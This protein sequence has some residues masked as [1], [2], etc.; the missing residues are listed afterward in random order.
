M[1]TRRWLL[2]VLTFALLVAPLGAQGELPALALL[3]ER[4]VALS[5]VDERDPAIATSAAGVT[6]VAWREQRGEF[7][8]VTYSLYDLEGRLISG[9][10]V[11]ASTAS[12]PR[13]IAAAAAADGSFMLA[14]ESE[15]VQLAGFTAAG[16][17]RPEFRLSTAGAAPAI[18][19]T[20]DGVLMLAYTD[21]V[22]PTYELRLRQIGLGAAEQWIRLVERS[23]RP[24]VPSVA[25][26]ANGNAAVVYSY[27]A[28]G[29]SYVHR[30]RR[31]SAA[32]ELNWGDDNVDR[33]T[34][35]REE[36]PPRVASDERGRLMVVW[37]Q[38]ATS[39]SSPLVARIGVPR[40]RRYGPDGSSP[41]RD[42]PPLVAPE[43]TNFPFSSA[44]HVVAVEDNLFAV[45]WLDINGLAFKRIRFADGA[46]DTA[47]MATSRASA[48]SVGGAD[49]AVAL[50]WDDEPSG[51]EVISLPGAAPAQA[52]PRGVTARL[53]AA[54]NSYGLTTSTAGTHEG[55]GEPIVFTVTRERTGGL[56]SV[57]YSLIGTAELGRDYLLANPPPGVVTAT[58][59]LRFPAGQREQRIELTIID[60]AIGEPG[61]T[62]GLSLRSFSGSDELGF[63]VALVTLGDNDL[64]EVRIAQTGA[65]TVVRRGA[66]DRLAVAL[67]TVP[68]AR[69]TL[70]LTPTDRRLNLG[71]GYGTPLR[72]SFAPD[73]SAKTQQ[74]VEVTTVDAEQGLSL[75]ANGGISLAASSDDPGYDQGARF[76]V[77]GRDLGT[78]PVD[79][80]TLPGENANPVLP[81]V[82]L[83][84]V[85]R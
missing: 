69:V 61:K 83:P 32:G 75:A 53:Y 70:T 68:A 42:L 6:V 26:D 44:P 50:A 40:Y 59:R 38:E 9:P 52:T 39:G 81:S 10:R 43:R 54:R 76:T 16:E 17:R 64:A 84:G 24:M 82:F 30:I 48:L 60:D 62:V 23:T 25:V 72:L 66:P 14:W 67:R 65:S 55:S 21:Y 36:H 2:P 58:G 41:D 4:G 80:V 7:Y 5:A 57:G 11:A 1:P 29:D 3:W 47:R 79:L 56:S 8:A 28:D 74:W 15:G 27:S 49:G 78:I 45:A 22:S 71:M 12:F 46:S 20:P 85:V 19:L 77:D 13:G 33:G 35:R 31:Y 63:P 18:A 51:D 34:A 37:E 73:E